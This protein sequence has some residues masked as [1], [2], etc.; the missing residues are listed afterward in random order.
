M[1]SAR[2]VALAVM[3]AVV[4]C[5]L[6]GPASAADDGEVRALLELKAA[7]D[8]TGRLLPSWA[9]GRDP[10]GG[11]GGGFEG[12]ACDARGGVA[13]LSLQGKGL[14]GTL[15]PA[16]AGL[17]ALTG[18]YLHYNALRGAVPRELTGLSQLT[19]LYLDVN[20]F[21]GAIPP[22]IGTMASLQ[23]EP[24]LL[25]FS[26]HGMPRGEMHS[27]PFVCISWKLLTSARV[28]AC[29]AVDSGTRIALLC[30]RLIRFVS[31]YIIPVSSA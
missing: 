23:G 3:A 11:G 27:S 16:V 29:G 26:G 24:A 31:L 18:L 4:C 8:P 17:R 9:P 6:P 13:N 21:S 20:N 22:E 30:I 10:C 15:S 2:L 14:S 28:V 25:L 19:D 7:L 1:A 12:V 5:S